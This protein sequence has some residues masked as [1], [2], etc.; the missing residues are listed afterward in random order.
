[1]PCKAVFIYYIFVMA[2]RIDFDVSNK[3]EGLEARCWAVIS[4]SALLAGDWALT[5][6]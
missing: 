3:L 2:T 6:H 5:V 4:N 1:M